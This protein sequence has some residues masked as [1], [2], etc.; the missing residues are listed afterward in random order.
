M[1]AGRPSVRHRIVSIVH[2]VEKHLLQLVRV[3]DHVGQFLIQFLHHLDPVALEVVGPQ[4]HCPPQNSIQL[5]RLA[6]RRHLPGET[7]QILHNLLGALRLLQNHPQIFAR[8]LRHLL[9]FHEQIG[10][11]QNRGERIIHLVG[12]ARDQLPDRRHFLRVHQLGL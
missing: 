10:K 5:H 3:S 7:Q 11:T 2:D 4:L 6:L 8:A 12:D 1:R 9:V